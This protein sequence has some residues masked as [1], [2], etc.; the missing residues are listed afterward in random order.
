MKCPTCGF[1]NYPGLPQCK[2]CGHPFVLAAPE[3]KVSIPDLLPREPAAPT[4]DTSCLLA[5][6]LGEEPRGPAPDVSAMVSSTPLVPTASREP[7]PARPEEVERAEQVSPIAFSPMEIGRETAAAEEAGVQLESPPAWREELTARVENFRRRRTRL[8]RGAAEDVNLALDFEG[9][10]TSPREFAMADD[11]NQSGRVETEPGLASPTEAAALD[12]FTLETTRETAAGGTAQLD[13]TLGDRPPSRR[14]PQAW[15]ML[16]TE[17]GP[18]EPYVA[19]AESALELED[20]PHHRGIDAAL[21]EVFPQLAESSPPPGSVESEASEVHSAALGW[22]FLAA[23]VDAL[24]LLVAGALFAATFWLAGGRL[25]PH[26]VN[27]VVFGLIAVFLFLSYF[28]CFTLVTAATPG[29]SCVGIRVCN[30]D[31]T[32]PTGRESWWRAFGYLVSAAA[33]LLGF[34][35]ALFDS[36]GLTWHDRMSGTLLVRA[37][38]R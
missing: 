27:I 36:E 20:Q 5:T 31:G 8:Q 14:A 9:T 28:A 18:G 2:K 29:L 32:A 21:A 22:R 6:Q 33:L 4:G 11:A 38:G 13:V 10:S 24:I 35:W 16:T 3:T 37:R 26:P 17:D 30:L 1:V 12:S 15:D 25:T 7:V 19:D 23:M 34:A